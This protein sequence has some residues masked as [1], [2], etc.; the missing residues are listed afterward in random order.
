MT[1][2]KGAIPQ[3]KH[4]QQPPPPLSAGKLEPPKKDGGYVSKQ[5]AVP[6]AAA[7]VESDA[8]Y[9]DFSRRPWTNPALKHFRR[10]GMTVLNFRDDAEHIDLRAAIAIVKERA[11]A[12]YERQRREDEEADRKVIASIAADGVGTTE[13]VEPPREIDVGAIAR[14][15]A[16]SVVDDS[17]ASPSFVVTS[18]PRPDD[19]SS[20]VDRVATGKSHMLGSSQD[21]SASAAPWTP[22]SSVN[23]SSSMPAQQ[24]ASWWGT[25][26]TAGGLPFGNSASQT[27]PVISPA[28][29]GVPLSLYS[30]ETW[31]PSDADWGSVAKAL[32]TSSGQVSQTA[33]APS[34]V[35]SATTAPG[36]NV[37]A[38]PWQP[39]LSGGDR[40]GF[41][42]PSTPSSPPAQPTL[43]T[44]PSAAGMNRTPSFVTPGLAVVQQPQQQQQQP[45]QYVAFAPQRPAMSQAYAAQQQ[46]VAYAYQNAGAAAAPAIYYLQTAAPAQQQQPVYYIQQPQPAPQAPSQQYLLQ[47]QDGQVYLY[48]NPM[49]PTTQ[50]FAAQQPSRH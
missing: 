26:G 19:P 44:S 42:A 45:A 22:A 1:K 24:N 14:H 3:P 5:Q 41:F 31:A 12:Q 38:A 37:A 30:D 21:L 27:P 11:A 28:S 25:G 23:A 34:G 4:Q 33:T 32:A 29:R 47:G 16:A 18:S 40:E 15:A 9:G 35:P 49:Q 36:S 39:M 43:Q 20:S 48:S 17:P 6:A 13:N 8:P 2:G 7:A 50:Y 46:S 10:D